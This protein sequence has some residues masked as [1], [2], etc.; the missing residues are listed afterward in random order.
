MSDL[1]N[2]F[3]LLQFIFSLVVGVKK[4]AKLH[5]DDL[6]IVIQIFLTSWQRAI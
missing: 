1:M 5:A 2:T 3:A 6:Q 4:K